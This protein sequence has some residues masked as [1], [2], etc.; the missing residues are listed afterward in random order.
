MRWVGRTLAPEEWKITRAIAGV[1][2]PDDPPDE[3]PP[4]AGGTSRTP[5]PRAPKSG[6]AALVP[7][8]AREILRALRVASLDR[9]IREVARRAPAASR[10][11][12]IADLRGS[13]AVEWHGATLVCWKD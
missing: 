5:E 12:I 10:A 9:V 6:A 4:P 13:A 3:S 7:T 2:S 11:A 1:A 8:G